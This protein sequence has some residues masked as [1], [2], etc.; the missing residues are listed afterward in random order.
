[1]V[2][3]WGIYNG[4]SGLIESV[5][6]FFLPANLPHFS[7]SLR[8]GNGDFQLGFSYV[9]GVDFSV[10]AATDLGFAS[11]DWTVLGSASEFA[12]GQFSFVDRDATNHSQRFYELRSR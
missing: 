7:G 3:L 1:M 9:S 4:S 11:N 5:R 8:T 2:A 6:E 12:P 10:Q